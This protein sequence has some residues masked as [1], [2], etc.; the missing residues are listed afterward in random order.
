V[1]FKDVRYHFSL[2]VIVP[3]I[4]AGIALLSSIL[5]FEL[6]LHLHKAGSAFSRIYLLALALTAGAAVCGLVVTRLIVMPVK[7]FIEKAD[8][9]PVIAGGGGDSERYRRKQVDEIEHFAQVF[10][11]VEDVLS[12]LDARQLFPEIIGESRVMRALLRQVVKVAPTDSTVLILGES[13]TGKELVATSIFE[14]SR[15]R[16]RPFI[17]LN[18]LA[19]PPEL[20]ESELFGHEKGAFTGATARKPGKF[21]LADGGTLFLDEI[22]DMPFDVQGKILRV[23][24]EK[25]FDRVGG[26][27]PIKV[28]VRIICA[29]NK[30]LEPMVAEGRFRE[31]LY[32]RINVFAL[33]LPRLR[34][35]KED[36]PQLVDKFLSR[37]SPEAAISPAALQTLIGHHWPGNVREL[38]NTIERAAVMS[39]GRVIDLPHLPE[40][41]VARHEP[42]YR[43]PPDGEC[44]SIDDRLRE[45][46]KSMI[47][48][49]L[50][51]T[52]GVQVRAAALMGINQRSLWH[53]IKKYAID[54]SAFK[55]GDK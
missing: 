48:D 6:T 7:R 52:N 14:N 9:L 38:Q 55:A 36:I 19:I 53:R 16:N 45:I 11:R 23:L 37:I 13:G 40:P 24:Q 15:R 5:T 10:E 46:E 33:H 21:E 34:E 25:E 31:D 32:Y 44:Q 30:S 39:E 51:R 18:C 54:A 50:K 35:R 17:K 3:V 22:G 41:L 1:P 20:M 43:P 27:R 28:D 8:T 42:A 12:K 26:T 2:Y 29:T 47:I 49:A 4:F